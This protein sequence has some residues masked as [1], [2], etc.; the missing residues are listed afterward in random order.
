MLLLLYLSWISSDYN[1]IWC[2]D[3][4]FGSKKGHVTKYHIFAKS[5]GRRPPYWKSFYAYISRFIVRLTQNLVWGSIITFRHRSH[6]QNIK[7]RKFKMATISKM[8]LSLYLSRV[9]SD[10][11]DIY[12]ADADSRSQNGHMTKYQNF[13]NSKWRTANIFVKIFL[14][15]SQWFIVHLM[16]NLAWWSMFAYRHRSCDKNVKFWIFKISNR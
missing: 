8:V 16:W 5:N 4:N 7:F 9:S 1:E 12:C 13:A 6:Y 10:V 14:V 11:K 2:A 15:T 3:A